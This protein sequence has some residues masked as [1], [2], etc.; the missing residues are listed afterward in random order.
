[1]VLAYVDN[2]GTLT[3]RPVQPRALH[4][5]MLRALDERSG[6]D[7]AFAVHRIRDVRLP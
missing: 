5:G 3:D 1:V 4:D 7:R 2:H 6:E